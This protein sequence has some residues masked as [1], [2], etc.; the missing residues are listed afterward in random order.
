MPDFGSARQ[1]PPQPRRSVLGP[2]HE[3]LFRTLWLAA[4]VSYTGTWMQNTGA[5]WLMTSLTMSPLMVGLVQAAGSIAVFL[6]VLPAGAIADVVDRRKLLLFTQ[7]WMVLAAAGL[8]ALTLA[9]KVTPALLL[10]F[11]FVMGIGA[12]LNDPAWQ[13]I[14]PEVVSHRNFAAGIALNSAGF[15]AARAIG[16]AL[17][18]LVIAIAGSG[19]AFVLNALSFFGVIYFLHGW[20]RRPQPSKL[21]A[22]QLG[23]AMF[24]GFRHM[25]QSNEMKAVLVRSATFSVC[26]SALPTLLP[27]VA[28]CYGS[29]GYGL[30]LGFFGAGAMLGA[31]VLPAL[32][33]ALS[34]DALVSMSTFVFALATLAAG[35]WE[36][37]TTLAVLLVVGGAAWIQILASLNVSAQTMS[38]DAHARPFHLDVPAGAAR[39]AGRRRGAVGR[40]RRAPWAGADSVSCRPRPGRG[41]AGQPVVSP[42]FIRAST[43]TRRNGLKSMNSEIGTTTYISFSEEKSSMKKEF[44]MA[45]LL[46]A[47]AGSAF[48][49]PVPQ[50]KSEQKAT[51]SS[52][53]DRQLSGVEKEVVSAVEAMP[54]NKM[55]YAPT[56][57]EFKGVRTFAQQAKH[58]AAVNYMLGAGIMNEKPPVDLGGENGPDNVKSKAEVVKFLKDSFAYLHK[59]LNSLDENNI[60]GQVPSPFGSGQ[61]S[62]L[63]LAIISIS[64]P[65]DHYG[66]IVEYL[67]ANGIVPPASRPK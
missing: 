43:R 46:L 27:L 9:G 13:A 60:L 29:Q 56:S 64:H 47:F 30:L 57:G 34:A 24:D 25:R 67:R 2:L 15:N 48:A 49:A 58:I 16:P 17:G 1:L 53:F 39:R 19:I 66:Q 5:A 55:D 26:A 20:K 37:F 50:A 18:G 40:G 44:A 52:V 41:H 6:V 42:A 61:A 23:T 36:G 8:A 4:V 45:V 38:P 22:R 3:P 54:E 28:H 12:V 35:R 62:R 32:R 14:T 65:M 63:G 10:L 11:T 51:F 21:Q 59:A 7:T 31:T 33:R